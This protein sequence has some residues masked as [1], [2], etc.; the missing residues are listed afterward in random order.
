MMKYFLLAIAA[1]FVLVCG[2]CALLL[3]HDGTVKHAVNA[4]T[5]LKVR[6][7][8][9]IAI[10]PWSVCFNKL[11]LVYEN[12]QAVLSET[13]IDFVWR[14][15]QLWP[16]KIK[17][18]T[19]H[20]ME[21]E[22]RT[23]TNNDTTVSNATL[24]IESYLPTT[25]YQQLSQLDIVIE[26]I[27]LDSWR[28]NHSIELE[29]LKLWQEVPNLHF[30][31]SSAETLIYPLS[32]HASLKHSGDFSL[33]ASLN[34]QE[35]IDFKLTESDSRFNT[36]LKMMSGKLTTALITHYLTQADF[37]ESL[38][39][40]IEL[41]GQHQI[42]ANAIHSTFQSRLKTK[43]NFKPVASFPFQSVDFDFTNHGQFTVTQQ[44]LNTFTLNNTQ[45]NTLQLI[46]DS[47]SELLSSNATLKFL[48][49]K[50]LILQFNEALQLHLNPQLLTVS[51]GFTLHWATIFDR[52]FI[53]FKLEKLVLELSDF[54]PKTFKTEH[55]LNA[56]FNK[57][58]ASQHHAVFSASSLLEPVQH[59][60]LRLNEKKLTTELNIKATQDKHQIQGSYQLTP[61]KI[62]SSKTFINQMIQYWDEDLELLS[63]NIALNGDFNFPVT[64]GFE[65]D[66]LNYT[67][68][69]SINQLNADYDDFL[70]NNIQ[71]QSTFK[72]KGS[73]LA[74]DKNDSLR[75]SHI[76]AGVDIRNFSVN[77]GI[78]A[79]LLGHSEVLLENLKAELLGGQISA[80]NFKLYVPY[81]PDDKKKQPY[82]TALTATLENI[83]L[84]HILALADN[85]EIQ[86]NG[87]IE[88]RLPIFIDENLTL[89]NGG[90]INNHGSGS[91]QYQPNQ[92]SRASLKLNPAMALLVDVLGHLQYHTLLAR[93]DLDDRGK[94][95]IEGKLKGVNPDYHSGYPIE[96]NPNIEL[97]FEDM[98]RSMQVGKNISNRIDKRAQKNMP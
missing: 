4:F 65:S 94:L 82:H 37:I 61:V 45:L 21:F 51:E 15:Q 50:N 24:S 22:T 71:Y 31:L 91:I 85:P 6:E 11:N 90:K 8:E 26:K 84:S 77:T 13:C 10:Q 79:D 29:K 70:F 35:Y 16:E 78:N 68:N 53:D 93:V 17:I 73:K 60:Q 54:Q 95:F 86:G 46:P 92:A 75:I 34:P 74:N 20:L 40:H 12:Y 7:L 62:G 39:T 33:H 30:S 89:I 88:G 1:L 48:G 32:L 87:L 57:H 83:Q 69:L 49:S 2:T 9:G 19:L 66:S 76:D 80:N 72:G 58:F 44:G 96:F 41:K 3:N 98:I 25:L 27:T 23:K 42:L 14:K 64:H 56:R 63:G 55:E 47:Q 36:H 81:N 18:A 43:S 5:P 59:Y 52:A 97:N 38:Q 67:V 28:L